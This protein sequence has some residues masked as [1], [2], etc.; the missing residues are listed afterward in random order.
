MYK[1]FCSLIVV[2]FITLNI[3]YAQGLEWMPD[4]EPPKSGP[5]SDRGSSRYPYYRSRHSES[6]ETQ[7]QINGHCGF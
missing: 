5:R 2:L 1:R 7:R 3:A 4:S 6:C